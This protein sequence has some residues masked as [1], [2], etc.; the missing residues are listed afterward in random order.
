MTFH[1][2][3][4]RTLLLLLAAIL[5][6][7][8]GMARAQTSFPTKPV[9]MIVAFPP[10]QA[11]DI[12]ARLLADELTKIWGR[13]VVVD[14][15]GGGNS[16]PGT[17]AGR[18]APPD[19]YT[20]TFATSSSIAVNPSLY[21]NLPYDPPKDFAMVHGVFSVPL[22]IVAHP[23]A[24]YNSLKE[25]LDAAKKNPDALQWGY[26]ATS[27]QLGAELFKYRTGASIQGIPYKGSGPAMTD[28]LGGQIMLLL[29]TMAATMPHIK[30]GKMKA[31]A[32]M[33]PKRVPQL[34]DVPTVAELGY[35]GFEASGW[36]GMVVPKATPSAVVHKISGDVSGVL[37]D[38]VMQQKI[39]ERG[40]VPDLRGPKEW[41]EFVNAE[42]V[43]WADI[44]R[45]A[46]VKAD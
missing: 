26:G 13:Q 42:L 45:R 21:S 39:I 28:L 22:I 20:I 40:A 41:T 6:S 24:P 15:R 9:R 18:N 5:A 1:K 8:G 7:L 27:L 31:L 23:S 16:I 29:D 38:P 44:A 32:I 33:T 4:T 12:V 30:A 11:T 46:N 37:N 19:G 10:G 17:V 43:K 3:A 14:N 34:P 36:G 2:L 35:A 25:M